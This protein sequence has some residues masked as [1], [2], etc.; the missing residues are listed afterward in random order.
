MFGLECIMCVNEPI[1]SLYN[2]GSTGSD[3]VLVSW[4][5]LKLESIGVLMDLQST[6]ENLRKMYTI[7]F[8]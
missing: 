2:V 4:S 1:N 3:P 5:F 7:Y 6:M 8:H